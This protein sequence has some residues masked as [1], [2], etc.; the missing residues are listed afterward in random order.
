MAI[1]LA[2]PNTTTPPS[3][4]WLKAILWVLFLGPPAA[5]LFIAT[6][7]PLISDAGWLARDL[8]STYVCPTP[9]KSYLLMEHPM[10]VCARCWGAT[11]GL[12]AGYLTFRHT[13]SASL[14]R[15]LLL[16]WPIRLMLAAVPFLLWVAEIT[17]WP[18][19]PLELLLLNGAQAGFAAGVFFC[20]IWPGLPQL[21]AAAQA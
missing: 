11:I 7:I 14:N 3:L 2:Q 19:A 5:A 13:T 18:T 9:A 8:L 15:Y 17:W 1:A 12:W 10:A 21:R 6:G 4:A 16:A 20:S